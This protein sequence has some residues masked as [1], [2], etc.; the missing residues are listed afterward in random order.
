MKIKIFIYLIIIFFSIP[1]FSQQDIFNVPDM[2]ITPKGK[3][4]LQE[5]NILYKGQL[6]SDTSVIYGLGKNLEIGINAYNFFYTL[7]KKNEQILDPAI[8][9]LNRVVPY[10]DLQREFQVG[11]NFSANF[12]KRFDY[13]NWLSFSIG[14]KGGFAYNEKNKNYIPANDVFSLIQLT[15]P[16]SQSRI[17]FGGYTGNSG[18]YGTFQNAKLFDPEISTVYYLN[19]KSAEGLTSY[20]LF[21]NRKSKIDL[22]GIMLGLDQPIL[23]NKIHFICDYISGVNSLGVSVYGFSYFYSETINFNIGYQ[24]PNKGS[25]LLNPHAVVTEVNYIF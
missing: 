11:Q 3:I 6:Q 17:Y 21:A 14:A 2:R 12:Q 22:K 1:L 18:F 20:A 25:G 19:N 5:Q 8:F 10:S 16:S 9:Y 7:K 15:I 24:V 23:K 13:S 4:F